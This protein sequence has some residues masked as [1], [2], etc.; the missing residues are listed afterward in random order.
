MRS[1][2]S[3]SVKAL[4]MRIATAVTAL[5]LQFALTV[6]GQAQPG[7][8]VDEIHMR[9]VSVNGGEIEY[10][11]RGAGAPVLLIHGSGIAA[12][13]LPVMDH[14][15]L[16][17]FE[18]I[19]YHRRGFAGSSGVEHPFTMGD[20]A[21]DAAA[22]LD[23]LNIS[24][25]HI[26]GHSY[27]GAVALQL[28][29]D[30]PELVASLALLEPAVRSATANAQPPEA[31][32]Q[33]AARYGA[34]DHGGAMDTLFDY[35]LGNDWRITS[36]QMT[37]GSVAQADA[38]VANTFEVEMPAM[39]QWQFGVEQAA[40]INAPVLYVVGGDSPLRDGA[41]LYLEWAPQTLVATIEG[42]DHSLQ[43]DDPDGVAQVIGEFLS[44]QLP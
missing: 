19:R 2:N 6:P 15:A 9:R 41:A 23:Q 43:K 11:R 44:R 34:G 10:E 40:A 26:V 1:N 5:T 28:A 12:S 24:G 4:S 13:F 21:A 32:L 25:A 3:L 17:G 35:A 38:D 37:P 29:L 18:V 27:G 39:L 33:A 8:A 30:R 16:E 22:L 7:V 36:E 42:V 20:Q 14:P 31:L